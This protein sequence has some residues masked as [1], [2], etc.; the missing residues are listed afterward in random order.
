MIKWENSIIKENSTLKDVIK[1]ISDNLLKISLVVD[2]NKSL[3]GTIVDGDIRRA[4]INGMTLKSKISNI[5]NKSP[6]VALA[7]D[8]NAYILSLMIKYKVY[9]IP[10]VD[11]KNIVVGLRLW[12]EIQ[13]PLR[14]NYTM[15]IMAG[16]KGI[17]L[18]PHT[19]H[20]PKSMVKVLNKPILEHIINRAKSNGF[21][22][23]IIAVNHLGH[24]IEEYFK[25]GKNFD[26]KINYLKEKIFLGTAGAL[27]LLK[28][29]LKEPFVVTNGDVL[30]DIDYS[31]IIEFHKKNNAKA[32]IAVRLHDIQHPFGVH[33]DRWDET[34]I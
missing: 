9:Q 32:T 24:I 11:E 21:S 20:C 25:D 30:T 1:N 12:D 18:K 13:S 19:T 10:I 7:Q 6:I 5:Y 4:L 28:N 15:I 2:S 16:G 14:L 17:R 34:K 29:K 22:D 8:N 31:K 26:V 23:F 33:R 27:S 3:I